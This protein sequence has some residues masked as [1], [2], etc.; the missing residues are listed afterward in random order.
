MAWTT[1]ETAVAGE[2]LTAAFLNTNV[3]DNT[4]DLRSYQNRFATARRTAG[5]LTLN[6]TNWAD[7]STSL[8]L[9]L[10]ASSGDV[11][12]VICSGLW[13]A[14]A[15]QGDLDAVTVVSGSPVTSFATASAV[16]A[17]TG[18]GVGAW[19]G[20]VSVQAQISGSVFLTLASGDVSS[21]NVL[22]RMRYRTTTAANKILIATTSIPFIVA[23]RNL[24]PVT[25]P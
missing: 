1:P 11:I 18:D 9:T 22:I 5:N 3:R 13:N 25:T 6:S 2:V 20:S 7:V 19:L 10:A 23:A 21:G 8:D 16:T 14:D 12:E 4:A 24:G 17:G 15:V